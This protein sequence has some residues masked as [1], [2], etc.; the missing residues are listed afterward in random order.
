MHQ[1]VMSFN[2]RTKRAVFYCR[3]TGVELLKMKCVDQAQAH[4]I[5]AALEEAGRQ[6]WAHRGA[7][8]ARHLYPLLEQR[9]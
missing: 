7:Q 2:Y 1:T 6:A 3:Y 4:A 5:S 8:I 9:A